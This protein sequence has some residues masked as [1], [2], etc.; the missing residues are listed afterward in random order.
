MISLEMKNKSNKHYSSLLVVQFDLILE[1]LLHSIHIDKV[2]VQRQIYNH[3]FQVKFE[4]VV[5]NNQQLV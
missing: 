4:Q 5:H 2:I 3:Q 1:E